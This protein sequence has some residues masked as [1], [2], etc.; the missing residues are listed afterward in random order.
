MKKLT[1]ILIVIIAIEFNLQWLN[2]PEPNYVK[3]W[4]ENGLV[5]TTQTVTRYENGFSWM[6]YDSAHNL[7]NFLNCSFGL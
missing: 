7:I 6:I 5:E 1:L 2:R 3:V 4:D